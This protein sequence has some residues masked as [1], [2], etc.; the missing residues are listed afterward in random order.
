MF[1]VKRCSSGRSCDFKLPFE[2]DP[3]GS[4]CICKLGGKENLPPLATVSSEIAGL[5]N[6]G[7]AM[8]YRPLATL[9]TTIAN[10]QKKRTL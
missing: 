7:P 1:S 10:I 4:E 2:Q 8:G 5:V 9:H 3:R 6:G